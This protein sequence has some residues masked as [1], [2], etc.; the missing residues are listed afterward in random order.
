MDIEYTPLFSST[1]DASDTAG[2]NW[3]QD[4]IELYTMEIGDVVEYLHLFNG[5]LAVTFLFERHMQGTL[6]TC[7]RARSH[8]PAGVK[9]APE[10]KAI[11]R[12]ASPWRRYGN[13]AF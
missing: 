4:P 1:D 6:L 12:E 11:H 8:Y 13:M 3:F 5:I 10:G 9:P 7:G 2:L